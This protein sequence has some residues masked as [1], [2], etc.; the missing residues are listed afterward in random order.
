MGL[1]QTITSN[2]AIEKRKIFNNDALFE[3]AIYK[4]WKLILCAV[5]YKRLRK[6]ISCHNVPRNVL[7]CLKYQTYCFSL[8]L[9]EL[10]LYSS[11]Y[12]F[13]VNQAN[14]N[15]N[16]LNNLS[17]DVVYLHI[18]KIYKKVEINK[19]LNAMSNWK[20]NKDKL[21]PLI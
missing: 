13:D 11:S 2:V 9:P 4:D 10:K 7:S 1:F 20:E 18:D 6:C 3:G 16:F 14:W 5:V 8:K 12:D 19:K 21:L 17:F 15:N